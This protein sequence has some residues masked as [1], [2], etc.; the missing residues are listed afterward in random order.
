MTNL[1]KSDIFRGNAV[2][3]FFKSR[4]GSVV[5]KIGL[6]VCGEGIFVMMTRYL[7]QR[8]ARK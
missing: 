2:S 3:I 1:L 4:K 8:H 7:N 6:K 5:K